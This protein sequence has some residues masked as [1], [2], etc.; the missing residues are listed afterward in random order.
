MWSQETVSLP[1]KTLLGGFECF[2]V[3]VLRSANHHLGEASYL[4]DRHNCVYQASSLTLNRLSVFSQN[5][6]TFLLWIR[7]T[8][9]YRYSPTYT[10]LRCNYHVYYYV[11]SGRPSAAIMTCNQDTNRMQDNHLKAK[12]L[13]RMMVTDQK[14]APINRIVNN[15]CS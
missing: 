2:L 15:I 4:S 7:E 6:Q 9:L 3:F 14:G 8:N 10:I 11:T 12:L 5:D 13:L 1:F